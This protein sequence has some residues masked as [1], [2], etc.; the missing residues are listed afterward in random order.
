MFS[1]LASIF[2]EVEPKTM[3][4]PA[5]KKNTPK[6]APVQPVPA[7]TTVASINN[8]IP[9]QID[10]DVLKMLE[11]AISANNIPGFDWFEFRESLTKMKGIPMT[12][13]Q[14]YKAV[15]ATAQA[16]GSVTKKSLIDSVSHYISVI[17]K[18]ASKFQTFVDSNIKKV[19]LG[20]KSRIEELNTVIATKVEEIN[21]ITKTIQE[22]KAEQDK[23]SVEV[24]NDE[25][26]V[27]N[28]IL[29]FEATKKDILVRLQQ[30]QQKLETYLQ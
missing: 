23:L 25:I 18:E 28:K 30:D 2:V 16:L 14:M 22:M 10:P 12:E 11:E 1:K 17:E 29:S 15:F 20:K 7:L 9:G 27:Q 8:S 26:G 4:K 21:T 5:E 19:I 13:E 24:Y 3:E 6:S